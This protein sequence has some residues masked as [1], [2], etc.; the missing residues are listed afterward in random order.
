VKIKIEEG[1]HCH[2]GCPTWLVKCEKCQMGYEILQEEEKY[3]IRYC[4][5]CGGR[6]E[7][8]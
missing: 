4:P 7:K 2:C 3:K 5:G 1:E 8:S 6:I